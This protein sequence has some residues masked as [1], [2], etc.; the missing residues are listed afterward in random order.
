MH[1]IV[2]N[3][4]KRNHPS[5]LKKILDE[6]T[7]IQLISVTRIHFEK[8]RR[9]YCLN[10]KFGIYIE[11]VYAFDKHPMATVQKLKIKGRRGDTSNH[12]NAI[13]VMGTTHRYIVPLIKLGRLM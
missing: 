12:L 6:K 7:I 9:K 4:K 13:Y 5:S 8:T 10:E 11:Q 3:T 1:E 2:D